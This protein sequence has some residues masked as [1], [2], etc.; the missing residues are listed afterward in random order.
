MNG[1]FMLSL[2]KI[3]KFNQTL[4]FLLRV[5]TL[6]LH[7]TYIGFLIYPAFLFRI[8]D[9]LGWNLSRQIIYSG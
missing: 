1:M 5:R 4:L 9:V 8:Q 7:F 2:V 6:M 3:S